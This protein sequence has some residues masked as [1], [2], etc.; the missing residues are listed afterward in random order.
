MGTP[1]RTL[2]VGDVHGCLAELDEL[3]AA[4]RW[5]PG[6]DRLVF[7]GDLLDRGPD[8]V[9]VLR[10]VRELGAECVLGNH[11]EK[12]LRYAAHEARR[13]DD[14]GYRNPMRRFDPRRAAEHARLSRDDLLWLA[15]LPRTIALGDRWVAVHGGFLP[16]VRVAAQPPDWT[17]RLRY[18]DAAGAPVARSRGDAGEPGVRR[19]AEVWTGPESV[20][21]GHF[22]L[23]LDLPKRDEPAPGVACLG[24]DT[25]CVYGGRLTALVLPGEE[26]VQVPSR[27]HRT[28]PEEAE[29]EPAGN[30]A[31]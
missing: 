29:D 22:P 26:I 15:G 27:V 8:P 17:L 31:A 4:A 7:L 14:K 9:G 10:R 2:V 19:W 23:R 20:V 16:G 6:R 30:G 25:G 3:I 1:R 18:V 11:E 5:A 13:R 12:H 28:K 21:Y 24:I